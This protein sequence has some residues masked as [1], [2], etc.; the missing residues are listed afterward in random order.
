[1]MPLG[2]GKST[3]FLG[4]DKLL[5]LTQCKIQLILQVLLDKP[6][7]LRSKIESGFQPVL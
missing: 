1:M 3:I 2:F 7:I 4:T 5:L 6:K